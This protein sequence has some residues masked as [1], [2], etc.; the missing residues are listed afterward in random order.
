[1]MLKRSVKHPAALPF[2][3]KREA[4]EEQENEHM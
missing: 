2:G 1:M 3:K 4:E